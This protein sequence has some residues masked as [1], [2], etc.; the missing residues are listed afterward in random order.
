[1]PCHEMRCDSSCTMSPSPHRLPH[2][3]PKPMCEKPSFWMIFNDHFQ[4]KFHLFINQ[5]LFGWYLTMN[6]CAFLWVADFWCLTTGSA[7]P[8]TF[9]VFHRWRLCLTII[10]RSFT[11][12]GDLSD[13]RHI[14]SLPFNQPCDFVGRCPI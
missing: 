12:G 2:T 6:L 9:T 3:T 1:M 5:E 13:T 4:N 14:F 11:R 10:G 8:D 7:N